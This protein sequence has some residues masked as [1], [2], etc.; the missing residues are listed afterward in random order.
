MGQCTSPHLRLQQQLHALNG[1][2]GGFG[3]RAGGAAR[4][5]VLEPLVGVHRLHA[6]RLLLLWRRHKQRR[7]RRLPAE[8]ILLCIDRVIHM[9]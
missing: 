9:E 6:A 4:Q 1:R 5:E 2:D 3:H 8:E 7:P